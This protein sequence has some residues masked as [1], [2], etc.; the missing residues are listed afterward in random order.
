MKLQK[1][2]AQHQSIAQSQEHMQEHKPRDVAKGHADSGHFAVHGA[3][4][5]PQNQ[6]R[7]GQHQNSRKQPGSR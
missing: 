1:H 3:G 6:Q 2:R 7:L 4:Q 5:Q